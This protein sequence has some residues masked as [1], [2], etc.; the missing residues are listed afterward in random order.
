MPS[1]IVKGNKLGTGRP[2][3]SLNKDRKNYLDAQLWFQKALE[4]L[5]K[6]EKP[7]LRVQM[8]LATMA[9]LMTKIQTL[10]VSPG[11]SLS[12]ANDAW[13]M[14]KAMESDP[15]PPVKLPEGQIPL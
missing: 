15:Q 4:E 13:K 10:P 9:Q 12:N 2:K 6:L 7:E 1:P 11:D 5:E 3:G 8:I 14:L